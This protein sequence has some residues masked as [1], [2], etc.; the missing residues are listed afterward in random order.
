[1][2]P[3]PVSGVLVA[4]EIDGERRYVIIGEIRG[5]LIGRELSA[6]D[7]RAIAQALLEA[8]DVIDQPR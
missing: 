3:H 6:A 4:G 7:A 1:V 5:H 2:K 8:A